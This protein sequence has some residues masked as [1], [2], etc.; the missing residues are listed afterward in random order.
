MLTVPLFLC[1]CLQCVGL[2]NIGLFGTDRD[3]PLTSFR[4]Q[5]LDRAQFEA[6]L[7]GGFGVRHLEFSELIQ[8]DLGDD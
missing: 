6:A 7:F 4:Q 8:D 5:L 2:R 3:G 1:N